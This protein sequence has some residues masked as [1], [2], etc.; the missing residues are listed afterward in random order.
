MGGDDLPANKLASAL[1]RRGLQ[2][3]VAEREGTRNGN[4][5][6]SSKHVDERKGGSGA[7]RKWNARGEGGKGGEEVESLLLPSKTHRKRKGR[8]IERLNIQ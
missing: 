4:I 6:S 5:M 8:V 1:Q 7:G 3:W 2:V